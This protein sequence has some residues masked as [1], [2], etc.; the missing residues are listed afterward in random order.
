M[1]VVTSDRILKCSNFRMVESNVE[2]F[3]CFFGVCSFACF[4][5]HA[6]VLFILKMWWQENENTPT[7]HYVKN[8]KDLKIWRKEK[9]T[10]M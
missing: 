8:V 10:K 4:F 6:V 1:C 7:K 2:M 9:T 3:E 5:L